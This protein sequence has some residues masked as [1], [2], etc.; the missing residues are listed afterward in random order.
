MIGARKVRAAGLVGLAVV[1]MVARALPVAAD[2]T[3]YF[4]NT[5][6][7]SSADHWYPIGD[8]LPSPLTCTWSCAGA[9]GTTGGVDAVTGRTNQTDGDDVYTTI[10]GPFSGDPLYPRAAV[11][12]PQT[13]SCGG[14]A[15]NSYSILPMHYP[16]VSRSYAWAVWVRPDPAVGARI[17][18]FSTGLQCNPGCVDANGSIYVNLPSAGQVCF[19]VVGGQGACGG[20]TTAAWH[21]LVLYQQPEVGGGS[22]D[23]ELFVD[24]SEPIGSRLVGAVSGAGSW[25]QPQGPGATTPTCASEQG[26]SFDA[27]CAVWGWGEWSGANADNLV[28]PCRSGATPICSAPPDSAADSYVTYLFLGV[29]GTALPT[30]IAPV[31]PAPNGVGQ[32]TGGTSYGP[33][34]GECKFLIPTLA[35]F[36]CTA[37]SSI[38]DIGSDIG[39]GLCELG[40]VF[41]TALDSSITGLNYL[42]DLIE[43]G[44]SVTSPVTDLWSEAQSRAPFSYAVSVVSGITTAF[45]AAAQAPTPITIN[46]LRIDPLG[47]AAYLGQWNLVMSGCVAGAGAYMIFRMVKKDL[48][49]EAG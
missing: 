15:F 40:N 21:L 35:T 34:S 2:T 46:G 32:C 37:P 44:L 22:A 20:I 25:Q 42:V 4:H 12:H 9:A 7:P 8:R 17:H 11:E 47:M 33:L 24:K 26:N 30:G 28:V 5:V 39:Y 23:L 16:G 1:V 31:V 13:G 19:G 45:G 18:M 48:A 3:D 14:C 38:W 6:G 43:P 29:G 41:V 10:D 36:D 49:G 27:D